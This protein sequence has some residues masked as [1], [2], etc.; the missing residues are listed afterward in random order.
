MATN[1]ERSVSA[2]GIAPATLLTHTP[3]RKAKIWMS[4][5]KASETMTRIW[6]PTRS[7]SL[8]IFSSQSSFQC[9]VR[10]A[11]QTITPQVPS[12]LS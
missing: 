11:S 8:L 9:L 6:A 3:C 1:S 10:F 4:F 12:R 5:G 2:S 7:A